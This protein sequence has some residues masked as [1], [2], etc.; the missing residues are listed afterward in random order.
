MNQSL[1]WQSL[2][3]KLSMALHLSILSDLLHCVALS[4]SSEPWLVTFGDRS[5]AVAGPRLWN[6]LPENIT[7]APSLLVF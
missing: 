4:T 3:A 6:T 1:N 5:S 2:S 7:S